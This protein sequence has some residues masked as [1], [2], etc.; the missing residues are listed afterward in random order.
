MFVHL[1]KVCMVRDVGVIGLMVHPA[2]CF[3]PGVVVTGHICQRTLLVIYNISISLL[4]LC[5]TWFS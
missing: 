2:A 4:L 1:I 3:S 5:E